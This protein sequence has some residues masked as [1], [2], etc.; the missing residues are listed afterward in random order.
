MPI[1]GYIFKE[2]LAGQSC[3]FAREMII[4]NLLPYVP[5]HSGFS[6]Y[7]KRVLPGLP[8]FRLLVGADDCAICRND[9]WLPEQPPKTQPLALLHQLAFTQHGVDIKAALIKAGLN[10][11]D[12]QSIYSPYCDALLSIRGTPQVIT[13]HD[14]TPLAYPN[15][16][17]AAFRYKIWTPLHFKKATAVI[18]ISRFV[19]NQLVDFGVPACK[20]EVIYN[21]VA[22]VR[23]PIASAAS[24][25]LLIIA[26]HDSNKNV[27]MVVHAFDQFVQQNSH[28]RG[29]LVVVG[30]AGS[31]S[32]QLKLTIA[33]LKNP[34]CV[35]FLESVTS[36]E[37]V[38]LL[39]CS[40]ALV[41]ASSMEGFD[42]PILEAKA[43][44]L[45][46]IIS[47]IPVHRELHGDTSLYFE[48]SNAPRSFGY[49][50]ERLA[51]DLVLW[52]YLG[53]QGFRLANSFSISVQQQQIQDLLNCI[54]S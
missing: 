50:L 35:V 1:F 3:C 28:W 51:G 38:Q 8:G 53:L 54:Q 2:N 32:R 10:M 25:D 16:R 21:G 18:A 20:I 52:N 29:R 33:Q 5:G 24:N 42:Y 31:E 6:S 41:S 36:T 15:S 27:A 40:F 7:V 30:R 4:S 23:E 14:L 44:G 17:K 46:T 26:R 9:D 47:D 39:R 22:I 48:L 49:A 34:E 45:P 19:A 12:V 43:E 11:N 13:C 37:L